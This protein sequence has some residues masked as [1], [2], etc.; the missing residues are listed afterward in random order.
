MI[1]G[2]TFSAAAAAGITRSVGNRAIPQAQPNVVARMSARHGDGG[3]PAA[4]RIEYDFPLLHSR[5]TPFDTANLC[6]VPDTTSRTESLP[7]QFKAYH[8][9]GRKFVFSSHDWPLPRGNQ[10]AILLGV[11]MKNSRTNATIYRILCSVQR[12]AWVVLTS[13]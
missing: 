6:W 12:L 7:I 8:R 1:V 5:R 2:M 13:V 11:E 10:T 3:N 4:C 9:S